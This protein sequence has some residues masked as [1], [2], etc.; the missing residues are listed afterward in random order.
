MGSRRER[1]LEPAA[2]EAPP[3]VPRGAAVDRRTFDLG[4]DVGRHALLPE[5]GDELEG[6]V[7]LLGGERPP[8]R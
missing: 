5:I 7:A 4:K 3:L 8:R 2:R 1:K 6:V